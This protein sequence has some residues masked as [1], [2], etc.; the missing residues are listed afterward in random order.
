M[1]IRK[2]TQ[3]S[4]TALNAAWRWV[5]D[6]AGRVWAHLRTLRSIP[7]ENGIFSDYAETL[8]IAAM[9]S[10]FAAIN[11]ALPTAQA[12]LPRLPCNMP[13]AAVF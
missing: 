12:W 9:R 11:L 4:E 2:V 8:F 13:I 7:H 10:S 6:F 3:G 1:L 5:R